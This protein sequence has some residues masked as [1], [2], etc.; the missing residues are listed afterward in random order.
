MSV[1]DFRPS[2]ATPNFHAAKLVGAKTVWTLCNAIHP[3]VA[4]VQASPESDLL[5]FIESDELAQAFTSE[6]F[7]VPPVRY[8]EKPLEPADLNDLGRAEREQVD[9]WNP[10]TVG[11]VIYNWFD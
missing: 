4:F 5:A 8:L 2:A 3:L 7:N 9:Y 11:A 1:S 10:P 6:G